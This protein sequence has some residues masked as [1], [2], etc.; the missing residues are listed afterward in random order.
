MVLIKSQWM[1]V[2]FLTSNKTCCGIIVFLYLL[3]TGAW[4]FCDI[5]DIKSCQYSYGYPEV[6]QWI[7]WFRFIKIRM[8][9]LNDFSELIEKGVEF[10]LAKNFI[11]V[12]GWKYKVFSFSVLW[13]SFDAL[14]DIPSATNTII[15]KPVNTLMDRWS[16]T[17]STKQSSNIHKYWITILKPKELIVILLKT[18]LLMLEFI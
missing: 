1:F 15:T 11:F 3:K 17:T 7:E 12:I 8:F 14:I 5:I 4:Y 6:S 2:H 16:E 10:F 9:C 18:V 13:I